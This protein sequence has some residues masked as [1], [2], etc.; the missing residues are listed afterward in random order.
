M[1]ESMT[2]TTDPALDL[3]L[4]RV[5]DVPVE[6]VWRAWTEP[7]LLLK[8]FV[9]A[10]WSLASCTLDLRPGGAFGTVIKSPEGEEFP[11]MGCFL[12]VVP[13]QRLAWTSAMD[14]GFRPKLNEVGSVVFPFT[15]VITMEPMDGGT[16]YRA[17]VL[18]ADQEGK[19]KHEQM[20][21]HQGWISALDQM[22]AMIKELSAS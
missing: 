6:L 1:K 8:W 18:H 5:V 12:E 16:L 21:F 17:L 3:L 2:P 22:V 15:A 4:E 7:E 13:N 20:G 9:P 10:P 14:P 11:G 19:E